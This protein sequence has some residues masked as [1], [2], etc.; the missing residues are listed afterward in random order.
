[1]SKPLWGALLL[2]GLLCARTASAADPALDI[3]Y[4]GALGHYEVSDSAR[5]SD[6]GAG[7]SVLFGYPLK[8]FG[9]Q[10]SALEF[11]YAYTGRTRHIDGKSNYQHALFFDYRHDF[12]LFGWGEGSGLP[13][14]RPFV[15]GG[16][17][18][19]D[20]DVR[21]SSSWH[22]GVDAGGGLLFPLPFWGASLRAEVRMLA[23][24]DATAAPGHDF[25]FDYHVGLGFE[26]PLTP[27]FPTSLPPPAQPQC[28]VA[29]VNPKTGRKDCT[30]DSDGDGVPDDL[31]QC[32]D[33]PPGVK[34]D[35]RGCPL[36]AAAPAKAG[37][38]ATVQIQAA[39]TPAPVTDSDSDGVPDN[40]DRCPH[41]PP[42]VAVDANGCPLP[43]T[44]TFQSLRFG[45][46]SARLTD[47]DRATLDNLAKVLQAQPGLRIEIDGYTDNV[48]SAAY[49][50]VLSRQ[51][52]EAVRQ[53]LIGR[54]V[55]PDRLVV[56]GFGP[57]KPIASNDSEAGRAANRRVEF[58]II[59]ASD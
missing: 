27:L 29:V 58:K 59:T 9:L 20:E 41:T 32:P 35:S 19:I 40:R 57:Y 39:P 52:A 46:D 10:R 24:Q 26:I 15:V 36:P 25:L 54:G 43:R 44:V 12:G 2:C 18:A 33:T 1:M 8:R 17:G 38:P 5:D 14:F 3:P 56:M 23:Q 42:G 53:Y 28:A 11:N 4:F 47:A 6:D 21:G 7:F 50:V 13:D 55:R 49:N 16:V 37:S 34:V 45:H 48:G 30:A 22:P 51:R 31:D